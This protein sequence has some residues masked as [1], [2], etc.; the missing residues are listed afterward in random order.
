MSSR[1]MRTG[2][3]A[4]STV[5]LLASGSTGGG[6]SKPSSGTGTSGGHP[7]MKDVTVATCS[8]DEAGDYSASLSVKNNSSGRSD[9]L[10]SVAFESSDGKTQLDTTAAL[11]NSLESGQSTTKDATSFKTASGAFTCRVTDVSRLASP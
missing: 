5:A 10:I 7:A 6:S 11:V 9:Y 4:L 1:L 8:A 2:L 3:L